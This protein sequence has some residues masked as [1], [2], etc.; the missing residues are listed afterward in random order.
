MAVTLPRIIGK[1]VTVT[2]TGGSYSDWETISIDLPANDL[3]QTAASSTYQQFT[4]G[5]T[6]QRKVTI[7]GWLGSNDAGTLPAD[8]DVVTA[9]DIKVGTDSLL[10]ADLITSNVN[11]AWKVKNPKYDFGADHTKYSFEIHSG[12]I[13]TS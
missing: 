13:P 10:P 11:G 6:A 9:I 5:Q 3:N 4:E 8:G 7:S 2:L 12:F 1:D